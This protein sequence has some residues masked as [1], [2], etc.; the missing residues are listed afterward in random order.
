M[1]FAPQS[2]VERTNSRGRHGVSDGDCGWHRKCDGA[3]VTQFAAP[4]TVLSRELRGWRKKGPD[5]G[6]SP[7]RSLARALLVAKCV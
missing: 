6:W 2:P 1:V 5:R 7:G 3:R 4:A